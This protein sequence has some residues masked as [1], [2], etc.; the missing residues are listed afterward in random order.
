MLQETA[1]WGSNYALAAR[2]D[3]LR[4]SIEH[5]VPR[6]VVSEMPRCTGLTDHNQRSV[7]SGECLGSDGPTQGA[8][9]I[10][11][12]GSR[13]DTSIWVLRLDAYC[14]RSTHQGYKCV[15][16]SLLG[17][18]SIHLFPKPAADLFERGYLCRHMNLSIPNGTLGPTSHRV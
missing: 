6:K 7:S 11:G 3:P 4:Y 17:S 14:P 1:G 8:C 13:L 16:M 18:S 9:K 2:T 10:S 15:R 5:S 12:Y